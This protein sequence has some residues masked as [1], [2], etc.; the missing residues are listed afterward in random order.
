MTGGVF[1]EFVEKTLSVFS[2]DFVV[3]EDMIVDFGVV[4]DTLDAAV[5]GFSVLEVS[6]FISGMSRKCKFKTQL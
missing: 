6:D 1:P 3:G 2:G 5:V 4:V